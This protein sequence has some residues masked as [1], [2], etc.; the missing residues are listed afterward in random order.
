MILYRC[1]GAAATLALA[2]LSVVMVSPDGTPL[3]SAACQPPRVLISPPSAPVVPVVIVREIAREPAFTQG[4]VL[5]DG[6]LYE[7]TG[8]YGVSSLRWLDPV[9]GL[10]GGERRLAADLFGEGLARVGT[11][12]VQLTWREGLALRYRRPG[13]EEVA[14]YR[15]AGE[16]WGLCHSVGRLVMS[17]GSEW[18]TFR[19]PSTFR[20]FGRVQVMDGEPVTGLNEL[21]CVGNA[22]FA[23]VW[24]TPWI[25]ALDVRTGRVFLRLDLSA[26][27]VSSPSSEPWGVPNGIAFDPGRGT[28]YVTGKGW[29]VIYEVVFPSG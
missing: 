8:L 19:D 17:D 26:V 10:V 22:V 20:A 3:L 29:P 2:G 15:Y 25:V 14:R 18:L 9:T 11:D 6:W 4:L 23:N 12:L 24:Q 16:G 13:L 21:E 1:S 7:S 28:F 5:A 27:L